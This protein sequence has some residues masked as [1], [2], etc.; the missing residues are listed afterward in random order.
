M[1]IIPT[2]LLTLSSFFI[3]ANEA[4]YKERLKGHLE[5]KY[6]RFTEK[7]ISKLNITRQEFEKSLE[8]KQDE[9]SII[10][11]AYPKTSQGLCHVE[12]TFELLNTGGKATC[13]DS[14]YSAKIIFL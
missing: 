2:L 12:A 5:S 14:N 9:N 7:A 10:L 1:K 8:I 13:I 6:N 4:D 3:M 11:N